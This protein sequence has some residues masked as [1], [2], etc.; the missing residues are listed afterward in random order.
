MSVHW[1]PSRPRTRTPYTDPG[2]RG[3][4]AATP[5]SIRLPLQTTLST[6]TCYRPRRQR[7]RPNPD[8][9]HWERHR[10]RIADA[11]LAP[12][13]WCPLE[14][15]ATRRRCPGLRSRIGRGAR[16]GERVGSPQRSSLRGRSV[17]GAEIGTPATPGLTADRRK[18]EYEAELDQQPEALAADGACRRLRIS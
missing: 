6:T 8:R 12:L 4:L 2:S 14:G 13:A 1:G 16:P 11:R 9:R 17:A 15:G 5:H 10:L 3:N 18:S 7:A